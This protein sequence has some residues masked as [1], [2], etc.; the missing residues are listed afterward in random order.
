MRVNLIILSSG[1]LMAFSGCASYR[2]TEF[3]TGFVLGD[4]L[5]PFRNSVS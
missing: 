3:R 2:T 4:I 5:S 1:A